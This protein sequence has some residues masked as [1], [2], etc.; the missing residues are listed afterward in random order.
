MDLII[1][2]G[3]EQYINPYKLSKY[4]KIF[5]GTYW[6]RHSFDNFELNEVKQLIKNRDLL[7][8]TFN[9]KS[10]ICST[11][12][13]KYILKQTII[14][15]YNNIINDNRDHIEYYKTIDGNILSLFS[16]YVAS[17]DNITNELYY[18]N[19]YQLFHPVYAINQNTYFKLIKNDL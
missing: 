1:K 15:N 4:P 19:G 16:L 5:I 18:N 11:K 10:R 9:I 7:V 8:E 14:Y 12:I 13:P 2:N 17:D 6:N 3:R